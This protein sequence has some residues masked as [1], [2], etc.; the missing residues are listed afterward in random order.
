M[1]S[2]KSFISEKNNFIPIIIIH[3][4]FFWSKLLKNHRFFHLIHRLAMGM[5]GLVLT[6][7]VFS[8]PNLDVLLSFFRHPNI[9]MYVC[10]YMIPFAFY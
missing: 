10:I 3:N 2:S 5:P 4:S 8:C 1:L 9:H 7:F 6:Y